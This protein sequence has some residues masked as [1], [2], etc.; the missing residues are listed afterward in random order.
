MQEKKQLILKAVLD[1]L[2]K[3]TKE[4]L[5]LNNLARSLDMGKSTLY[6]YFSSKDEMI[7]EAILSMLNDNITYLLKDDNLDDKTFKEAFHDHLKKSFELAKKNQMLQNVMDNIEYYSMKKELKD[8]IMLIAYNTYKKSK[9]YFIKIMEKGVVEGL[10]TENK[11]P[12][13]ALNLESLIL[14]SIFMVSNPFVTIDEESYIESL[15]QNVIVLL[16]QPKD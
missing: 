6:E 3:E 9:E 13:L 5:T 8:E 10:F 15:Y 4:E 11:D 2:T 16:N 14:G 7:K 1:F 12:L